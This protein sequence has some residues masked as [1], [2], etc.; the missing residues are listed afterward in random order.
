MVDLETGGDKLCLMPCAG[1][2]ESFYEKIAVFNALR[3]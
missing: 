2:C 1:K 3:G